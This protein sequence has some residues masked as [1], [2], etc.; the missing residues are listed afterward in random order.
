[1]NRLIL[2]E[3]KQLAPVRQLLVALDAEFE[4]SPL[5]SVLADNKRDNSA[6]ILSEARFVDSYKAALGRKS[7]FN[8]LMSGFRNVLV[9]PFS[10]NAESLKALAGVVRGEVSVRPMAEGI[11][12]DY[13]V[14]G[15]REMCGPFTGLRVEGVWSADDRALRFEGAVAHSSIVAGRAGSLLTKFE[16]PGMNLFVASTSAVFDVSAEYLRN[17]DVRECFSGLVPL[18]FFLRHCRISIPETPL[19][20]ANWII[21]DPNL[22]A[23]YGFLDVKGLVPCVRELGAAASIAFIPWNHRR[24]ARDVV[25]L[26]RENWPQLAICV[27]G[28]DHTGAEFSTKTMSAAS[29]LIDL[30]MKRMQDLKKA[31]DLGFERIM[32][33]PQGR[34]SREAMRALRASEMLAAVNTEL[35]DCQTGH[36]VKGWELLRPAIMS[37]GGFPLF[38]RR[39]AEQATANFA[40]DMILGKPC[41]IVTHHSYFAQ[42]LKPLRAVVETLNALEPELTWTNLEQGISSTYSV[43]KA[44][45]ERRIIRLYSPRTT[46]QPKG[47]ETFFFRKSETEPLTVALVDGTPVECSRANGDV[48][49][50]VPRNG[51]KT[52]TVDTFLAAQTEKLWPAQ[53][54]KYR[55]KVTARRYL[56]EVRDN[57]LHRFPRLTAHAVSLQQLLHRGQ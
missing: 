40:L 9:Y 13:V 52:V 29:P 41:L 50:L 20:W 49:F 46:F 21:D 42:G 57:Y 12:S 18:L 15:S 55:L 31:T 38:V 8:E 26:F 54:R 14:R 48:E 43:R 39:P 32:V 25:G 5:E 3:T 11:E 37:F 35:L 44:A 27:H 33:F 34:F 16:L 51:K 6:L 22:R 10:G 4:A 7:T 2:A 19:R 23:R 28:C 24:T 1:M 47:G 53:S 56:T 36:G 30:A 45:E 17:L